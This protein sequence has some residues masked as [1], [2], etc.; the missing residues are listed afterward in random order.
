MALGTV[1]TLY[2]ALEARLLQPIEISAGKNNADKTLGKYLFR[3][4]ARHHL[5]LNICIIRSESMLRL[6]HL[7]C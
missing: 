2:D 4:P 6:N 5:G 3:V 1:G 7:F